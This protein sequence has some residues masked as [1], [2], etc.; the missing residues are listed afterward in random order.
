MEYRVEARHCTQLR[1]A[2][3]DFSGGIVP[4]AH[5]ETVQD[6]SCKLEPN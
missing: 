1:T 3:K 6:I 5:P 2:I 4:P